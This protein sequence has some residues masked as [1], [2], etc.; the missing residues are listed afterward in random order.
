MKFIRFPYANGDVSDLSKSLPAYDS[1]E[2]IGKFN[3][4]DPYTGNYVYAQNADNYSV[5]DFPEVPD[6]IDVWV[7]SITIYAYAAAAAGGA[8]DLYLTFYDGAGPHYSAANALTAT[9]AWYSHTWDVDPSTNYAW[10]LD[11]IASNFGVR[12][13]AAGGL[14]GR[15]YALY[16]LADVTAYGNV[17]RPYSRQVPRIYL[18][19]H[20]SIYVPSPHE[21]AYLDD[22][23]SLAYL[24][25]QST[26]SIGCEYDIDN[27]YLF[28]TLGDGII[29]VTGK[30]IV[31]PHLSIPLHR[32]F[33]VAS[34]SPVE[35]DAIN[36]NVTEKPS[37]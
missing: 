11:D 35:G 1:W 7:N 16:M 34:S 8:P 22:D 25:P 24:T 13:D 20:A 6:P 12:I 17:L 37:S 19:E 9:P 29:T 18:G 10:Y 33:G 2:H 23:K 36:F 3:Y 15:V 32:S 30:Y 21:K 31:T 27:D 14:E 28:G 26:A 4:P 5:W